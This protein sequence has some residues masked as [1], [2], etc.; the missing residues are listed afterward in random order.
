M[1]GDSVPCAIDVS[2]AVC[3]G[4]LIASDNACIPYVKA[5]VIAALFNI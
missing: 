1:S 4:P 2:V 5:N 3:N